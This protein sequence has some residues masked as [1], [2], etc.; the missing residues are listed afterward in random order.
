MYIA[1]EGLAAEVATATGDYLSAPL[2]GGYDMVFMSA[3]VH[4]NSADDNRLLMRKSAAALNPGGQIVVQDFLMSEARDGPLLPALFALN[5]L[6]GT[7]E[8]DTYTE[9]EVRSWMTEAGCRAI[10]RKDTTFG[11]NLMI[12]RI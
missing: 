2:G 7:P 8:G 3:V 5:M 9:S 6:V 10:V 11:T 12:G 1:Q 4:S